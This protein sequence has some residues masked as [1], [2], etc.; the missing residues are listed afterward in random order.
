MKRMRTLSSLF[1]S[2]RSIGLGR[3]VKALDCHA[4]APGSIPARGWP[5][6]H[7]AEMNTYNAR[8]KCWKSSFIFFQ[9]SFLLNVFP[10]PIYN[11]GLRLEN[12]NKCMLAHK[13]FNPCLATCSSFFTTLYKGG[14]GG[15]LVPSLGKGK[16]TEKFTFITSTI[17]VFQLLLAVIVDETF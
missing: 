7:K 8:Q 6:F 5:S 10:P 4:K 16:V 9:S 17:S 15:E 2:R 13:F 11:V 1:W 3:V 12:D 14:G